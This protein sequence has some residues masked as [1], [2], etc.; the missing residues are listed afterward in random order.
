M[1]RLK[2]ESVKIVVTILGKIAILKCFV[3]NN[4]ELNIKWNMTKNDDMFNAL[5][6]PIL[7]LVRDQY[8]HLKAFRPLTP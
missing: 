6:Y 5:S 2:K 7:I 8:A 3:R 4:V 1:I